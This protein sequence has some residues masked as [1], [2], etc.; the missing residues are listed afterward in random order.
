MPLR[1]AN[2]RSFNRGGAARNRPYTP[3]LT[4]IGV[5]ADVAFSVMRLSA[6]YFGRCKNVRRSSDNAQADIWFVRGKMDQGAL[7]AFIG[8]GGSG[9]CAKDYDQSGNG[10]D[11][12]QST[13]AAQPQVTLFDVG[14]QPALRFAGTSSQTLLTASFASATSPQTMNGVAVMT[15]GGALSWIAAGGPNKNEFGFHGMSNLAEMAAS[16]VITAPA[17]DGAWHSITAVFNGASSILNVDGTDT[18][19]TDGGDLTGTGVFSIGSS[20]QGASFL[21][22]DIAEVWAAPVA[23]TPSQYSITH[24]DQRARFLAAFG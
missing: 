1:A 13:A 22:G 8:A 3:L 9:F 23:V 6:N 16:S 20:G 2:A 15:T 10:R 11:A 5:N 4:K 24:I 17:T 21:T 18:T 7:G 19:A 14:G 12:S